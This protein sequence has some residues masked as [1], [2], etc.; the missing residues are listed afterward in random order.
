[1]Q[2]VIKY[3]RDYYGIINVIIMLSAILSYSLSNFFVT[4]ENHKAAEM[5]IGELKYGI[6]IGGIDTSTIIVTP[7]EQILNVKVRNLNQTATKYKLVFVNNPNIDIVYYSST[8]DTSGNVTKYSKAGDSIAL[9]SANDIKIKVKN[10]STTNQTVILKAI[11]GFNINSVSAIMVPSEYTEI[12]EET[13]KYYFCYT[14]TLLVSGTTYSS[15]QYEYKYK[16][17][18]LAPTAA[19]N[20]TI[21]WSTTALTEDGWGV[22]AKNSTSITD[23]F[24]GKICSYI[25]DKPIISTQYMYA[26][27]G[28][29]GS[30]KI[31]NFKTS[32][33][34]NMSYMFQST[35]AAT[36][37]LGTLDT[38]NVTNMYMM[39]SS[40]KATTIRGYEKFDTRSVTDMRY[41]FNSSSIKTINLSNFNT[42]KL[43]SLYGMFMNSAVENLD[44]SSFDTSNVKSLAYTFYGSKVTILDLSSFNTSNVINTLNAFNGMTNLTTIYVS[45]KFTMDKVTTSRNM[46]F[47]STNLV[48]GAGTKYNSN[49]VDKTYARIDG[50]TS[51]PGYFTSK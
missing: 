20:G 34:T 12:L 44:V 40:A 17:S 49:Y 31:S 6:N 35:S 38:S 23:V 50:G 2:K 25:D 41:M 21:R 10:N 30:I 27:R 11:G 15:G 47:N 13:E 5:Y 4:S 7:G 16:Y 19:N 8:E 29:S 42:S 1:M 24:D 33:V 51:S 3:I 14:G 43:T 9:N 32:S 46:F 39:F 28:E 48:G 37:D 26:K 36:I 45:D 22:Q 18:A